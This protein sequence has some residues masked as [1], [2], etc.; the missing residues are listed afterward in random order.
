MIDILPAIDL[1]DGKC[2][3]LLQG[4]YDRQIDYAADPVAV[5]GGFEAAGARWVH[6]VDLDGARQGVPANLETIRR[7]AAAT[8]MNVEVGGGIREAATIEALFEIGVRRVVIGTKAVE[9][10]DWFRQL[11]YRA[12]FEG[13]IA[14]GLDARDGKLAV[15]GWTEQ[16]QREAL[17]VAREVAGWPLGGGGTAARNPPTGSFSRPPW[18]RSVRCTTR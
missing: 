9:A 5:A 4:N 13:R 1:R 18:P 8:A 11:T 14:L 12:G 7:I 17:E 2:V 15:K 3:R 10:W 6:V 16:T